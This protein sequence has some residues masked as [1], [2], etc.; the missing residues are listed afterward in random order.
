MTAIEDTE[1]SRA[2]LGEAL[3]SI[4]KERGW[5]LADAAAATGFS[6][7]M[8][9]K[10]EN[11]QRSL[12]YDKL[13]QL[14]ESLSIDISRLFT[15]GGAKQNRDHFAGRRSVHRNSDGFEIEAGVYTYHYLAHDL[16]KKRF[17]PVIMDIHARSAAEFDGLIRHEGDEFA[18]V[19]E[20]EIEVHTETYAPLRLK[21]GESVFFDSQMG[22]A[23][24]NA[25]EGAA[26]ILCIGTDAER[27]DTDDIIP[28]VKRA[29]DARQEQPSTVAVGKRQRAS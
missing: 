15:S 5:S 2:T 9:S 4:R 12:T 8:L 11:G 1:R 29:L 7:S 17:T 21:I 13:V 14:A 28:F 3:R 25:G 26:R 22:H 27:K 18:Y 23:Y 19:I 6:I 24:V 20:G 10:I 16:I